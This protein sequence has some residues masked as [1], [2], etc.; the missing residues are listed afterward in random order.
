MSECQLKSTTLNSQNGLMTI[1]QW[2]NYLLDWCLHI[3]QQE[4]RE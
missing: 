4:K 3:S 1:E 2:N